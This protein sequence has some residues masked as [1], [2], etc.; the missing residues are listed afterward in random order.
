MSEPSAPAPT[1]DGA[2]VMLVRDG[3]HANDPLEVFM[4]R[5]HPSTAFGSVHVFPGGVVDPDDHD[6]A[7]DERCPGLDDAAASAQLGLADGGRAYWVAAVREA[8]EEAGVLLARTA[9]GDY[10]RFD[11]HPEVDARFEAH[12]RALNAGERAFLD[13]LATEDLCLALG[14]VHYVAHWITPESEPKRFDTRFFLAR[15]P[16]GQAYSHDDGEIIA[17]EWVRPADALQRHRAGDFAMIGPTIVSL[18]DLARFATCDDLFR[19]RSPATHTATDRSSGGAPA[20][21]ASSDGDVA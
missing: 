5:R 16:E 9:T 6:L 21:A 13:V 7:L 10:V 8:F 4:L 12:R 2:T 17:S 3:D 18:R 11:D 19:Q 20:L 1:R 15:A 14:D